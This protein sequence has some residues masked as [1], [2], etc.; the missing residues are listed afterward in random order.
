MQLVDG[1]AKHRLGR[2]LVLTQKHLFGP[3][4]AKYQQIWIKFCTHV[5][6]YGIRLL[7]DID[8]DR[9]VGCSRRSQK[10]FL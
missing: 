1:Q 3:R 2:A 10:D 8:R 5:L 6:L 4:T 7:A 9:R